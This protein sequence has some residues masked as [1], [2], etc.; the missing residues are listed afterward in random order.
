MYIVQSRSIAELYGQWFRDVHG[1]PT[2]QPPSSLPDHVTVSDAFSSV[3]YQDPNET[4]AR[5]PEA[6]RD[7]IIQHYL[8]EYVST[9]WTLVGYSESD[10]SIRFIWL[11]S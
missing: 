3:Y 8:N 11:K 7:D 1:E 6:F 2:D 9:G 5:P 10:M 4:P